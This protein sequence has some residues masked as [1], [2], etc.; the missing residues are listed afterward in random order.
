MH[1]PRNTEKNMVLKLLQTQ[2]NHIPA[3]N[4]HV[5]YTSVYSAF[6]RGKNQLPKQQL[7]CVLLILFLR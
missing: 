5:Y 1:I 4:L 7:Y 3:D 2:C 6:K